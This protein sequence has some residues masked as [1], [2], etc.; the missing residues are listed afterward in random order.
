M[1]Q[2]QRVLIT[3]GSGYLGRHVVKEVAKKH[4]TFSTFV[5]RPNKIDTGTA[6]PL[7][8]T[9]QD[10]VNHGREHIQTR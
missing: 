6:Y 8:I 10:Q 5:S 2:K 1:A 7:D 3:G 4:T 9:D